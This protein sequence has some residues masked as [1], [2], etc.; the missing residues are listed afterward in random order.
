MF[1]LTPR[2]RNLYMKPLKKIEL[3]IVQAEKLVAEGKLTPDEAKKL[4][5]E[6]ET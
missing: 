6:N 3:S 5:G 1:F 2:I 4:T